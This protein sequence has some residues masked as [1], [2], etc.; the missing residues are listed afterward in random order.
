MTFHS[1][2]ARARRRGGQL[3]VGLLTHGLPRG[4]AQRA[5]AL[6]YRR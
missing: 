1:R 2:S 3:A 4:T 6:A 5:L